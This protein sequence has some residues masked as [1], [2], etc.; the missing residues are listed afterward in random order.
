MAEGFIK[1]SQK[2]LDWDYSD[3]LALTGFWIHLLLKAQWEDTKKLRRG[4]FFTTQDILAQECGVHRSTIRRYLN[5]LKRTGQIKI[6]TNHKRTKITILKW[7]EYQLAHDATTAE[8]TDEPTSE[9]TAEP[10]FIYKRN[11]EIKNKRNNR[12]AQPPTLS[13][14]REFIEAEKLSVKPERFHDY[15]EARGWRNV[16]DWK[17]KIREWHLTERKDVMPEYI[18]EPDKVQI[19]DEEV[20]PDDIEAMMKEL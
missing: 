19:P 6:W 12:E 2:L 11:K 1:V 9:P 10:T 15:Y 20:S 14:I 18:T 13:E 16:K 4:E 17:K 3:N 5:Q 7:D 8:P